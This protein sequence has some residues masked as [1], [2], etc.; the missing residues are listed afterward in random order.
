MLKG[1]E[2]GD[3]KAPPLTSDWAEGARE[4]TEANPL[5]TITVE[6]FALCSEP[7]SKHDA[8]TL[9]RWRQPKQ[10]RALSSNE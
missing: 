1:I 4:I 7:V 8:W 10:D 5:I 2:I 3:P 9:T 6:F